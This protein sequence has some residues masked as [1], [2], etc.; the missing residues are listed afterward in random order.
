MIDEKKI[1]EAAIK[2][3]ES[4]FNTYD[5]HASTAGFIAGIKWF[6]DNLWHKNGELPDEST[7]VMIKLR[8]GEIY[9]FYRMGKSFLITNA[10]DGLEVGVGTNEITRCLYIDDLLKG[11]SNG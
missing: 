6:L 1:E 4:Q 5:V 10:E 2:Y 8:N 9:S 11:A 3:A 7:S